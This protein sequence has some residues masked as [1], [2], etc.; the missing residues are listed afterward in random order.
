MFLTL[1]SFK[2]DLRFH[3]YPGNSWK[4][5]KIVRNLNLTVKRICHFTKMLW[6]CLIIAE[7]MSRFQMTIG[8]SF[9]F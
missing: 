5:D 7:G 9:P 3:I 8:I 2:F 4:V 1:R 6:H